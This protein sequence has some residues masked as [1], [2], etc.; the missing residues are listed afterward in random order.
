MNLERAASAAVTAL[1]RFDASSGS[2]N[3]PAPDDL[4]FNSA[5]TGFFLG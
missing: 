1:S 4:Y 2:A 3:L 5:G